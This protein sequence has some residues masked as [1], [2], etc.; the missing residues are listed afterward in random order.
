MLFFILGQKNLRFCVIDRVDTTQYAP[1]ESIDSSFL[2]YKG[3]LSRLNLMP[4]RI[5][6]NGVKREGVK[7]SPDVA[8][9]LFSYLPLHK[10]RYGILP[11]N[12]ASNPLRSI[13]LMVSDYICKK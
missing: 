4:Y 12:L 9:G 2:D 5:L 11:L 1:V 10:I 13:L 8:F 6:C 7:V 3:V